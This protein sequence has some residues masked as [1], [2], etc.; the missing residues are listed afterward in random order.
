MEE[1]RE[2]V[3]AYL[4]HAVSTVPD[5]LAIHGS[6][7]RMARLSGAVASVSKRDLLRL[8]L[9]QEGPRLLG[10]LNPFLS[11]A[12]RSKLVQAAL[13]WMQLCVLEDRLGRLGR[14]AEGPSSSM[15]ALVQVRAVHNDN[16]LL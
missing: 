10:H 12:A 1:Q 15:L 13:V 6:S 9:P 7:F 16:V 14:L 11:A 3:E 4:L 2:E 8:A 5:S